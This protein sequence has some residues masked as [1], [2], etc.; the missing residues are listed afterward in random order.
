MLFLRLADVEWLEAVDDCVVLH[1]GKETHRVPGTLTA[2]AAKLPGGRF[3]RIGPHTL[4]N[5]DHIQ[6]LEPMRHRRCGLVL[7]S[8]TRLIFLRG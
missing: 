1:V 5:L 8:G 6:D 2:L 4:V 7:R 3:R